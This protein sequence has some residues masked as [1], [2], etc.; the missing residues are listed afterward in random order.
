MATSKLNA[1]QFANV[2]NFAGIMLVY[3][4]VNKDGKTVSTGQHFFGKD[5]EAADSSENEIFRVIKSVTGIIWHT[6]RKERE[7]RE[8]ADGIRSKF[9]AA[10]PSDVIIHDKTGMCIEHD[11]LAESVW[12][13]IGFVPTKLD[14]ERS[15][16]DFDKAIHNAAKAIR[17]ALKFKPNLSTTKPA[18]KPAVQP[19]ETAAA[20]VTETIAEVATAVP[21]AP[22][23]K[24]KGK[25]KGKGKATEQAIA[26]QPQEQPTE[27]TAEVPTE[28]PT[29][30]VIESQP[31][32]EMEVAA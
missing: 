17:D 18:E 26:E 3:T 28:Q 7:L 15:N 25:G 27:V 1:E 30:Q 24:G 2:G 5:F 29:E 19:V 10:T 11:Y 12:A 21:T 32:V 6:T 22:A 14:L 23:A 4:T 9:R 20:T 31:V 13:R 8:S 16:R